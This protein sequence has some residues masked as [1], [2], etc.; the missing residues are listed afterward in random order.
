MR[1]SFLLYAVGY[2][3]MIGGIGYGLFLLG[4]PQIWIGVAASILLGAGLIY[5]VSR[6]ERDAAMHE[7]A[8]G[9]D[10]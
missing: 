5:S 2:L 7:R 3:M 1:A 8:A 6:A 10:S 4:I 9:S